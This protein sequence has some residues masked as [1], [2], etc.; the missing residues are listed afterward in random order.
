MSTDA[1]KAGLTTGD[2]NQLFGS[3]ADGDLLF[4]ADPKSAGEEEIARLGNPVHTTCCPTGTVE[5]SDGSEGCCDAIEATIKAFVTK[6][7]THRPKFLILHGSLREASCSR[8]VAV[9]AGRIL[10]SY[11]ADV[12][13]FDPTGLP[14]FSAD[15]DPQSNEKV[16]ELR[17]LTQWC[18]GM[19]WISPE[20][21]GNY[22]AAFKN[23]VDWMPLSIGAIRPTQGKTLAV[24]QVEAGSQSFNTVNNLRVLGR[25]MRMTV[26]PNQMSIPRAYTEFE[27][28]DG[29]LKESSY[30]HR[31]VD[32]IDELFKYTL[33]LRDQQPYLLQRYSEKK[34]LEKKNLE[35]TTAM[36]EASVLRG[37]DNPIII[38]VRSPKEIEAGKGGV[39]VAGS[40]PVPI[41]VDN[42]PQGVHLTTSEEF[43]RKL[44]AAGVDLSSQDR[45]F[46]T[47][48]TAGNTD[49]IGR[50]ARAAALLRNLGFVNAH[51]GGSADEIRA[52]LQVD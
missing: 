40:V 34:A 42:Q 30:K 24:M 14:V 22:S 36:A 25:W 6:L 49:Y 32:V 27:E 51:N 15:M 20:V 17:H 19:V 3:D 8:K 46:I 28:K 23:Q 26:I 9:E 13:L 29:S 16:V 47:H 48:C 39:P 18:E 35:A 10:A 12:K 38:D 5:F 7:S 44:E 1:D 43:K 11:S 52:A 31:L 33:L 21:H 4:A 2:E 50:G 41:N 37:L 45:A